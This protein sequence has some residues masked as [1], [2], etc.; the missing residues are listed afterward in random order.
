MEY[1]VKRAFTY[2]VV[3]V[4]VLNLIFILPRLVPGNAAEIFAASTFVPASAVQEIATRLGLNQPLAGQYITYLKNVFL[5][6]PPY[7]GVSYAYYPATV[8]S[9]FG[10]RIGWTLLLI[11]TS[12]G[13]AELWTYLLGALLAL[14]RGGKFEMGS[15]YSM[16]TL[17]SLPIFWLAMVLLYAGAIYTHVFPLSGNYAVTSA[18][19]LAYYWS[20]TWHAILPVVVLAL[21]FMGET[22]L[23][24]RGSMQEVLKSDFVLTARSRGLSN[25]TVSSGYILRNSLLPLISV[26]SF[27]IAEM[28]SR[29]ILVEFVFG[30]PG[31]GDLIVD[32]V[33][34]R[35]YPV[36]EGSLFY[37]VLLIIAGGIVGDFLLT[38]L[39]PR[40]HEK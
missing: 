32:A 18:P 35:D 10:S 23:L 40:L 8:S 14:R 29:V 16:I 7:F 11:L 26:V 9:L 30:Y 34:T 17:N 39:D 4:V 27:A 25:W 33:L 6:F 22:F 28:I 24:L 5:T 37:L 3:F 21:S 38:R 13:L 15:L 2:I 19:G 36:L 31:V 20:V 12:M 1:L